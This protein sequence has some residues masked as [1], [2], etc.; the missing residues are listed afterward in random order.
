MKKL[1]INSVLLILFLGI[2]LVTNILSLHLVILESKLTISVEDDYH[3]EAKILT[4]DITYL[5][6]IMSLANNNNKSDRNSVPISQ[7]ISES[8]SQMNFI[9]PSKMEFI[10]ISQIINKQS[11]NFVRNHLSLVYLKIPLQPPKVIS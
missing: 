4:G 11:S 5:R 3:E 2:P 6:A 1:I 8:L 7:R 9:T 10:I